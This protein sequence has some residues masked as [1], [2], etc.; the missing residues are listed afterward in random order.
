MVHSFYSLFLFCSIIRE[1]SPNWYQILAV[2]LEVILSQRCHPGVV[3]ES[4]ALYLG[5][6]HLILGSTSM[7]DETL[8]FGPIF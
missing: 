7:L 1:E 6:L 4:L 2:I 3:D 8:N 5:D